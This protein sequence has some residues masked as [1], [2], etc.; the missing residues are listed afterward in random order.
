MYLNS[1][2]LN[3]FK[4]FE[5][6]TIDFNKRVTVISGKTGIGKTSILDA[7]AIALGTLF[8]SL[9]GAHGLGINKDDA[10]K[11]PFEIDGKDGTFRQYYPVNITASGVIDGK[12]IQWSRSL[13]NE[14][15]KT[16][17]SNAREM[18]QI[19]D[20]YNQRIMDGDALLVLPIIAYYRADRI[21]DSIHKEAFNDFIVNRRVNGY[22][23]C[24]DGAV[25]NNLMTN[26]FI[27]ASVM[28]KYDK[29]PELITVCN[30]IT[31]CSYLMS[32]FEEIADRNIQFNLCNKE[33]EILYKN[34]N[35]DRFKECIFRNGV[36][37]GDRWIIYMIADIA[38]RMA[39]LNPAL[40]Y[41]VL[42]ENDG[43]V[44][45]DNID[46]HFDPDCQKRVIDCLTTI[47]PK[48]QFIVTKK[49]PSVVNA[50]PSGS[51]F[52]LNQLTKIMDSGN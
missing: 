31:R 5:N 37:Y 25:N 7:S 34:T 39:T 26:W 8:H 33:L 11:A 22:L 43:V 45:I 32:G 17:I 9:N 48:V 6:F 2:T 20:L 27:K 36:K 19:S 42:S 28:A 16:T 49:A 10:H 50:V 1:L 47:F 40:L 4:G 21:S 51:Q 18:T 41:R 14:K 24:L 15:G 23:K 30:A 38:Y 44:L 52:V 29:I 35:G 3:N 46:L 13:R 12:E